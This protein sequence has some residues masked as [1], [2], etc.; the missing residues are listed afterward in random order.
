MVYRE[1]SYPGTSSAQDVRLRISAADTTIPPD[2]Q[3]LR[4][5]R[6]G[7][8][9]RYNIYREFTFCCLLRVAHGSQR[10]CLKIFRKYYHMLQEIGGKMGKH[11]PIH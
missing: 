2:P 1:Q 8:P 5:P 3:G 9:Q 6:E 10:H 7:Q 4:N 11:R